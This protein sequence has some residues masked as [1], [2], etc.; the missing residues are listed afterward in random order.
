MKKSEALNILGL[1]DGATDDEVKKAHRKLVIENHPDKFGDDAAKRDAAEEK[2]KLI[3]EA[4]DVL[5]SRKW[6]PEYRTAGTPYA[7][8]F[9][10]RP[11]YGGT[12]GA[13][14]F[15]PFADGNPFAGFPFGGTTFVWTTY[16]PFTGK[17]T[18]YTTTGGTRTTNTGTSAGQGA[19]PFGSGTATTFRDIFDA[20]MPADVLYAEVQNDL[21]RDYTLIAIKL[22][23]LILSVIFGAPGI[24]VFLWVIGSIG[25]AVWHNL[26]Y[27]SLIF[28]V[29]LT[30]LAIIFAPAVRPN[31]VGVFAF[32]VFLFAVYYDIRSIR[33]LRKRAQ[34]AK[35]RMGKQ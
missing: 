21:K 30:M 18:T 23:V 22:I 26:R 27:L 28:L 29:P 24:G 1:K 17:Q 3:N 35:A 33:S 19:N 11:Q 16:D 5:I 14:P 15:D 7:D 12:Q 20:A 10:Y 6:D 13:N 9:S 2:T 32:I 31:A 4:R 8:P 25:R 34:E